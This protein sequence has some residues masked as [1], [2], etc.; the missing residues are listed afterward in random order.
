MQNNYVGNG[1]ISLHVNFHNK[2]TIWKNMSLVNFLQV[3]G[4]CESPKCPI[5]TCF[6]FVLDCI[7]G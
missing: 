4:G 7:C 1:S 2:P 3:W 6:S 5:L